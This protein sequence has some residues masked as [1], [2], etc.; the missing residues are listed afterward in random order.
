M[1]AAAAE[2]QLG[3]LAQAL[4]DLRDLLAG[5]GPDPATTRRFA[6]V[7]EGLAGLVR[8][9]QWLGAAVEQHHHCQ[10]ADDELRWIESQV[11]RDTGELSFAWGSLRPR[12]A[13][14]YGVV[15]QTTWA[16]RLQAGGADLDAAL[17]VGDMPRALR[18]FRSVRSLANRG[19]NQVDKNLLDLCE[20]LQRVGQPL[21]VLLRTLVGR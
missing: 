3:R 5:D 19:F 15:A 9:E 8:L 13:G 1:V 7:D 11:A 2:L 16:G 4:A 14:L 21:A 12:L 10:Q 20:Q 17:E 6:A 18:A